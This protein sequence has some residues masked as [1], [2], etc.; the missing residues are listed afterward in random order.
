MK[1]QEFL[2]PPSQM[3]FYSST[4]LLCHSGLYYIGWWGGIIHHVICVRQNLF[5]RKGSTSRSWFQVINVRLWFLST[6]WRD[7]RDLPIMDTLRPNIYLDSTLRLKSKTKKSSDGLKAKAGVWHSGE[8]SQVAWTTDLVLDSCLDCS[9]WQ[10][11][12]SRSESS[13]SKEL[14]F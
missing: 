11:L 3:T 1:I 10:V 9:T 12:E 4:P 8:S 7:S 2:C 14:E 5:S 13:S 6:I